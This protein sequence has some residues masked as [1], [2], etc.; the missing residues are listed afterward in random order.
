MLVHP[1]DVD[2]SSSALRFL[3]QQLRRHRRAIGSRWRRLSAGRQA[4]L[5]LAHLRMGHTYTQL[6]AGFGIGTTTAYR[7][8]T[9]AVE[10]LA[11]LALG[12]TDAVRAASAKAYLILDGTLLPIDRIT[13]DRPF[14]FGKHKRQR[15]LLS[16]LSAPRQQVRIHCGKRIRLTLTGNAAPVRI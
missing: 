15:Q 5:T 3:T 9:E 1:P 2:V 14:Y 12:L 6:A 8:V 10:L 13:A 4:L 11:A 16:S 7:Y